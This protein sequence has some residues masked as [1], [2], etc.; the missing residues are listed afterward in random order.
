VALPP[1]ASGY[2]QPPQADEGTAAHVFQFSIVALV[3]T[4]LLFLA[5]LALIG[6]SISEAPVD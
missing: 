2:R 1:V 4:I 6:H 3:P 5:N